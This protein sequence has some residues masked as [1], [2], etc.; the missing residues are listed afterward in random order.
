MDVD[1]GNPDRNARNQGP[2]HLSSKRLPA[3]RGDLGRLLPKP[4]RRRKLGAG[5]VFLGYPQSGG[6]PGKR[7]NRFR[8]NFSRRIQKRRRGPEL[9]SNARPSHRQRPQVR[10]RPTGEA[11][12]LGLSSWESA[13]TAARHGRPLHPGERRI[14]TT[15]RSIPATP[16]VFMSSIP[17]DFIKRRTEESV[18]ISSRIIL[19]GRS[20]SIPPIPRKLYLGY[21]SSDPENFF[22]NTQ[23]SSDGGQSWP[24]FAL[25]RFRMLFDPTNPDV[26]Y[27]VAWKKGIFK[28]TDGGLTWV[29]SSSGIGK[30]PAGPLLAVAPAESSSYNRTQ[31]T[32]AAG[33]CRMPARRFEKHGSGGELAGRKHRRREQQ[34]QRRRRGECGGKRPPGRDRD[35]RRGNGLFPGRSLPERRWRRN[36]DWS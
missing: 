8:R 6:F 26:I 10:P 23:R 11:L 14:R 15:W 2:G 4:G 27:A 3:L 24:L 28:S 34:H 16:Y 7:S 9:D 19:P 30:L 18:G 33:L 17:M 22:C 21:L 13:P 32:A 36:M 12:C 1:L 25:D 5:I 31:S 35:V 29:F 20:P